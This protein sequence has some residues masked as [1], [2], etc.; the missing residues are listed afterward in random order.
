MLKSVIEV[1]VS[2]PQWLSN[3]NTSNIGGMMELLFISQ[4]GNTFRI[5]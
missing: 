2:G 3:Y 5:F 1:Y 4:P